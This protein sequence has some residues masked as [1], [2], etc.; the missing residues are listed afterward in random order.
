[1][2]IQ[3]IAFIILLWQGTELV[4]GHTNYRYIENRTFNLMIGVINILIVLT[5]FPNSMHFIKKKFKRKY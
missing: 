1:M 4:L 2:I 3:I 5:I